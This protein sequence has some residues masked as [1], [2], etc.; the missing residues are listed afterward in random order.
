MTIATAVASV[1]LALVSAASGIPKVIGT[2]TMVE[3][4]RHLGIP[5]T[6]YTVIGSLELAAA[7][8]LLAGL[9]ARPL[10]TAAAA[11]L[12]LMMTGAVATHTRVGDPF[13]AIAPALTVGAASAVTLALLVTTA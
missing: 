13:A 12:V 1:L 2:T 4:A 11:G 6:G 9:A 3:E 5:R 8:A 7:V 10:G